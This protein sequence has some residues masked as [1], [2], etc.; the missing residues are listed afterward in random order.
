MDPPG[1]AGLGEAGEAHVSCIQVSGFDR[2]PV[3]V[4]SRVKSQV[5][6]LG[7]LLLD[8]PCRKHQLSAS[9][10]SLKQNKASEMVWMQS[11][12]W[13]SGELVR[14]YEDE[15]WQQR[16]VPPLLAFAKSVLNS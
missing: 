7:C 15:Q 3:A 14:P 1:S 2:I 11:A 9:R 16:G 6:H 12:V 8:S 10:R 4:G 13:G 5:N